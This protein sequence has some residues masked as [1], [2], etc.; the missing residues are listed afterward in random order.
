MLLLNKLS[1]LQSK[2][3]F[4]INV[5]QQQRTEQQH[6]QMHSKNV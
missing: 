2:T 3:I 1:L 5:M 6:Q 4:F